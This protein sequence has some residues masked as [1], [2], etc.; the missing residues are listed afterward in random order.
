M[1]FHF[2]GQPPT[3]WATPVRAYELFL[4]Q[5]VSFPTSSLIHTQFHPSFTVHPLHPVKLVFPKYK[6]DHI[7]SLGKIHSLEAFIAFRRKTT[8][9]SR[10]HKTFC[11]LAPTYLPFFIS[12]STFKTPL[13]YQLLCEAL[14]TNSAPHSQVRPFFLSHVPNILTSAKINY[15]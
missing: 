8:F 6:L 10:R 15:N 1:T 7:S 13:R 11:K 4:Q 3:K 12:Y 9:L 14:P 5:L 2:A